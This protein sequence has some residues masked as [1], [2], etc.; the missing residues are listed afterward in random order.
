MNIDNLN[1]LEGV[2]RYYQGKL[3]EALGGEASSGAKGPEGDRYKGTAKVPKKALTGDLYRKLKEAQAAG[4]QP[5]M[6]GVLDSLERGVTRATDAL[7]AKA[8]QDAEHRAAMLKKLPALKP[9]VETD[10]WVAR[11][12]SQLVAGLG[13]GAG[14]VAVG[15]GRMVVH[16]LDSLKG[17]FALGEHIPVPLNPL[18]LA[19]GLYDVAIGGKAPLEAARHHLDPRVVLQEDGAFARQLAEGVMAPYRQS[20]REGKPAEALGRGL[21]DVG[22]LV[23]AAGTGAQALRG[24]ATAT[25]AE[26]AAAAIAAQPLDD[27]ARVE[28]VAA[29][30]I[31]AQPLDDVAPIAQVA[32]LPR[33]RTLSELLEHEAQAIWNPMALEQ[34]KAALQGFEQGTVGASVKHLDLRGKPMDAIRAELAAAG[35]KRTDSWVKD[36]QGQ[37]RMNKAGERVPMEIWLH[38][39]GGMVRLKPVRDDSNRFRPQPHAVKS[40]NYPPDADPMDFANEAFKV[41]HEG[42]A[43][44]KWAADANAEGL[45]S[46]ATL[47][48]EL[49]SRKFL[50]DLAAR[51]HV[52]LQ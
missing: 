20:L 52:D 34:A 26:A 35:F 48:D 11:Q 37:Y 43:L 50:D 7:E 33:I 45:Y 29:A 1:P 22:S 15:M 44:P 36:A 30:A 4:V 46:R 8:V 23:F 28:T 41:D 3:Q 24:M 18:R 21:F 47:R 13:Q 25:R 51:T 6:D 38:E 49:A 42:R 12:T 19:H 31:A 9:L 39:D 10:R 27:V 5:F 17:M 16:P 2:K 32:Q 40:V 14:T